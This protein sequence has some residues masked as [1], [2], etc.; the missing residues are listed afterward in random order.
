MDV[1]ENGA[2]KFAVSLLEDYK[3]DPNILGHK[4]QT[5][6]SLLYFTS[7]THITHHTLL[8][9]TSVHYAREDAK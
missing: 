8:R 9:I 5:G 2:C 1:V 6:N 3:A 7:H 4:N